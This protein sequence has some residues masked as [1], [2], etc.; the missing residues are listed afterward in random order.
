MKVLLCSPYE[1]REG[2]VSGGVNVWGKNI[3]KYYQ[4]I[5]AP[6]ELEAVSYDREY[7]V[8]EDSSIFSRVYHGVKEYRRAIS[9]TRKELKRTQYDVVHLCSS[10]QLSLFK[11]YIVAKMSQRM[12]AKAVV[13]FHFG[14]IPD[15]AKKQNWEW[16]MIVEVARNA[17]RVVVMDMASYQTLQSMGIKNCSYLPNPL[18]SDI[19]NQVESLRDKISRKENKIVFV[20]HVIVTKGV[21][22]LVKACSEIPDIELHI[23]GTIDSQMRNIITGLVRDSGQSDWLKI[24]GCMPH[25]K[26]IEE[27]LSSKIFALPS[28]TEGFPN[29]ILESM[30]CGCGIVTT[31]VG[32]IPEMLNIHGD[33]PCGLVAAVN[34]TDELKEKLEII[35][36]DNGTYDLLSNNAVKRVNELYA[37]PQV[38]GQLCAIWKS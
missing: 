27:M 38:W 36:R 17:H 19:I 32:A 16:K 34:D 23:I 25:E 26:V 4:A 24:R 28:Y 29:V 7:E 21:C 13:H 35:L 22:E 31:P 2:I 20:G 37:M 14:R 1:Q 12:G 6:L 5:S 18:S 15:L 30:A 11:D 10:A 33:S 3:L 9:K 8:K